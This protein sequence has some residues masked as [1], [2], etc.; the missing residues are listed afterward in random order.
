MVSQKDLRVVYMGTPEFA[1][2]PLKAI[3]GAGIKVVAVVTAPDKPAGRGQ[4]LSE[5]AVKKY[6]VEQKLNILQPEKLKDPE[7]IA[8]IQS[9]KPDLIVVVA[10]R[11]LP[12][13]IWKIPKLGTFNLHASLLPHYRGAAP[14]NWAVINGEAKTGL[15]TF[16][17]DEQID[18]GR[19]IL[20]QEVEINPTE[21][22][23]ALHDRLMYLGGPLVVE[24]IISL[25]SGSIKPKSQNSMLLAQSQLKTAPK[26]FK[27][28]CRISWSKSA[29]EV[30]NFIR[31]LSPYPAA[32]TEL[33]SADGTVTSAKIFKCELVNNVNINSDFG[34]VLTDGNSYLNIKCA[35]GSI[36]VKEIQIAGKRNLP[37]REFLMGFRL[38]EG[39]LAV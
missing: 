15:T 9:L 11:M 25:A 36:A 8:Q 2:E 27:E 30:H 37:I 18:T 13:S 12:E 10:F 39:L 21:T 17:I 19:V 14:I 35:V 1:V 3:L 29:A 26:L 34:A 28:T 16:L 5:S 32:W 23:G 20:Q 33:I 22:A 24:T 6:S 38:T 7:F 31:G 4:K